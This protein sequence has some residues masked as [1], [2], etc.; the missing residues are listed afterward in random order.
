MATVFESPAMPTPSTLPKPSILLPLTDAQVRAGA[1]PGESWEQARRRLE[2]ARVR[3]AA[4]GEAIGR[5]DVSAAE[6]IDAIDDDAPAFGFAALTVSELAAADALVDDW[7]GLTVA[8]VAALAA[9][10]DDWEAGR[11]RAYRLRHCVTA[12][13][14]CAVCNPDGVQPYGGWLDRP[15]HDCRA[16]ETRGSYS[17]I[18]HS[19]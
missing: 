15:G 7:S 12:C 19:F 4:A 2:G 18:P 11:D 6:P 5:L 13:A 1:R 3:A 8:Q 14:P 16:C 10:G 9:P 17:K